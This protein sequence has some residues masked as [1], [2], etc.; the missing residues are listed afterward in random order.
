MQS[1]VSS[2]IPAARSENMT[3]FRD[4]SDLSLARGAAETTDSNSLTILT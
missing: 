3:L 4:L 2:A 1:G